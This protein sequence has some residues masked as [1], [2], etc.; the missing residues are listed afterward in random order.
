MTRFEYK[1]VPAPSKAQRVKGAKGTPNKF[2]HT[3]MELMNE[4]GADGWEYQRADTL[5]CEERS[6]LTSRT[7]TFQNM[8]VFRRA[9]KEMDEITATPE[10]AFAAPAPEAPQTPEAIAAAAAAS[11]SVDAPVGDAPEISPTTEGEAPP[12]GPA[13]PAASPE[14]GV[15][16]E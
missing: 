14:T 12:V 15:A 7:T 9:I 2:A 5:P 11:L 1:V 10:P 3:L 4:L 6:G 13:K 8:L 16:A